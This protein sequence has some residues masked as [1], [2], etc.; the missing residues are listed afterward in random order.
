HKNGTILNDPTI[1]KNAPEWDTNTKLQLNCGLA[2]T[3]V[4]KEE[5]RALS[6]FKYYGSFYHRED[7]VENITKR[8]NYIKSKLGKTNI[9]I[10]D[11]KY[12]KLS[13]NDDIYWSIILSKIINNYDIS[14][15]LSF[16]GIV[17]NNTVENLTV[18]TTNL[19]FITDDGQLF[20]YCEVDNV[21]LSFDY[22]SFF[23]EKTKELVTPYAIKLINKIKNNEIVYNLDNWK[24]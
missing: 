7:Y 3:E 23:I 1:V 5:R 24:T 9:T 17:R 15:G 6:E 21:I 20:D 19:K 14:N 12:T 10:T 4:S 22:N 11:S 13:P 18:D 2:S 8:D 16:Q